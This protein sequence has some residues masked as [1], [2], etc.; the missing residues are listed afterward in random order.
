MSI[1]RNQQLKNEAELPFIVNEMGFEVW[2]RRG[3]ER[4]QFRGEAFSRSLKKVLQERRIP[5][6][7]R[8][9]LPFI[10]LQGEI[11]WSAA[12]GALAPKVID[13]EGREIEFKIERIN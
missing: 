4:I 8:A 13:A 7:E 6:W 10:R 3:G 9:W 12:L 11:I 1:G 2:W 5:P